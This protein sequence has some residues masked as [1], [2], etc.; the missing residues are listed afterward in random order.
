M[1]GAVRAEGL[2]LSYEVRGE[3]VVIRTPSGEVVIRGRVR[4]GSASL[5]GNRAVAALAASLV[6]IALLLKAYP[7]WS[8]RADFAITIAYYGVLLALAFA[9]Y[10]SADAVRPRRAVIVEGPGYRRAFIVTNKVEEEKGRPR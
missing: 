4:L 8:L 7:P 2:A 6:I 5:G 9:A 10:L 3:E 1:G